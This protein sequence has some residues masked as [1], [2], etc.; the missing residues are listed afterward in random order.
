MKKRGRKS[1]NNLLK[2]IILGV[3]ILAVLILAFVVIKVFTGK[4]I[5]SSCIDSDGGKN[6]FV[7]GTANDTYGYNVIDVCYNSSLLLE[8]Y[9]I[10]N[11]VSV[12]YASYNCPNGC[13]NDAC[14][15]SA[16]NPVCIDTDN[17]LNWTIKGDIS[18]VDL[19]GNP[20][21]REDYCD[22]DIKNNPVLMEGYCNSN[23]FGS[24]MMVYCVNG[25]SNGVCI[26]ANSEE[27]CTDS[28]NGK[29]YYVQGK[30]VST[31]VAE[32]DSCSR[33]TPNVLQERFCNGTKNAIESITCPNGCSNGICLGTPTNPTIEPCTDSDGGKNYFVKGTAN[34][35][36]GYNITDICYNSSLLLEGYCIGNIVSVEYASYNCPNG[37]SNGACVTT[38]TTNATST[39]NYTT[40]A[41]STTPVNQTTTTTPNESEVTV[42]TVTENNTLIC[43]SGCLFVKSCLP[44]GHRTTLSYCD[45]DNTLKRQTN[46]GSCNNNFECT[47]NVCVEGQCTS[48]GLFSRFLNWFKALFGIQ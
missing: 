37:C 16:N 13:S 29:N 4:V 6:Y 32:N 39:A 10:G 2:W 27:W 7:K 30:I 1:K 38:P 8:G 44:Y 25:C 15:A 43:T 9:C 17:G 28:D 22:F 42:P 23:V 14:I 20:Y 24:Y 18:G 31:Y 5:D 36:Y 34:D 46:G 35:M 33:V 47:S 12:E 19:Y 26:N 40:N 45:I 3:L 48:P 21:I 11:I 41:T